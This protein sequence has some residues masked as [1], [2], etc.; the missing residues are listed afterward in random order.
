MAR[1]HLLGRFELSRPLRSSEEAY[2]RA[3]VTVPHRKMDS[4]KLADVPEKYGNTLPKRP[5]KSVFG[6]EGEYFVGSPREF[7]ELVVSSEPPATQPSCWCHWQFQGT[8]ITWN[9]EEDFEKPVEWLR[10][11]IRHFLDPWGIGVDGA[12]QWQGDTAMDRGTIS[13]W[14]S[15]IHLHRDMVDS[16]E[17]DA[18][19]VA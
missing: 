18:D 17:S 10:Y 4:E 15:R 13:V 14:M 3:F 16:D 9:G 8:E 19:T 2:L 11:I 6:T 12:V 1:T 7:P 5:R